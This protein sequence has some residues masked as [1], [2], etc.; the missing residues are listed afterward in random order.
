M[1]YIKKFLIFSTITLTTLT[2]FAAEPQKNSN[3]FV[4]SEEPVKTKALS[5]NELKEDI[6]SNMKATIDEC[7]FISATVGEILEKLAKDIK[8]TLNTD[9]NCNTKQLLC[10]MC[11]INEA[12]GEPLKEVGILQQKYSANIEKLIENKKPFKNAGHGSLKAAQNE[13]SNLL[14]NLKNNSKKLDQLKSKL[15]EPKTCSGKNILQLTEE[16]SINF[17]TQLSNISKLRIQFCKNEC[18]K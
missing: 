5:K 6:G 10:E 4:I 16:V 2:T 1:T 17:K 14:F 12:V 13:S 9:K 7:A 11:K 18:L 3:N 15:Y 8:T